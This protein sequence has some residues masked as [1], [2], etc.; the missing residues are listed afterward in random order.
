MDPISMGE[1]SH[2]AMKEGAKGRRS[3]MMPAA[4]ES[5]APRRP[6]P[7]LLI[8]AI[9]IAIS[10]TNSSYYAVVYPPTYLYTF[11]CKHGG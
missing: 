1:V 2:E 8:S 5:P 10:I 6:R 7:S 9:F 11:L 4:G 3:P